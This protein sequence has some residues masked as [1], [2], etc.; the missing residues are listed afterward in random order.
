MIL[1]IG[2]ALLSGCL[3]VP[4]R[5]PGSKFTLFEANRRGYRTD[6]ERTAVQSDGKIVVLG[7]ITLR[8]SKY[9]SDRYLSVVRLNADGSP[10]GSFLMDRK[11]SHRK[12]TGTCLLHVAPDDSLYII[13]YASPYSFWGRDEN[14]RLTLFH[15]SREGRLLE[16]RG[17]AEEHFFFLDLNRVLP[18]YPGKEL[19]GFYLLG[20]CVPRE[21]DPGGVSSQK[22]YGVIRVDPRGHAD[23]SFEPLPL[24]NDAGRSLSVKGAVYPDGSLLLWIK[25][26]GRGGMSLQLQRIDP[27]GRRM[28]P[29]SARLAKAL[30]SKGVRE[31]EAA[32]GSEGGAV[33]WLQ[34]GFSGGRLIRLRPGGGID[35]TFRA[36]ALPYNSISRLIITPQK[37]ILLWG[38][39]SSFYSY[40]AGGKSSVIPLRFDPDGSEDMSLRVNY[41]GYGFT[42][43]PDI[44]MQG[45]GF[46]LAGNELIFFSGEGRPIRTVPLGSAADYRAK[47]SCLEKKA[48]ACGNSC[49][50]ILFPHGMKVM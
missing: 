5:L 14:I 2:F 49:L 18:C 46:L 12:M 33:L 43:L 28:E 21:K 23:P 4:E 35:P 22:Y 48:E 25:S 24:R 47:E 37:K 40:R 36:V 11:L 16:E 3:S 45:S 15:L 6:V 34:M 38:C 50:K 41:R 9:F 17:L 1:C 7:K 10:D 13:L 32:A 27:R 20:R 39:R 42:A 26:M 19:R 31:I 8:D 30:P 29:F 44:H